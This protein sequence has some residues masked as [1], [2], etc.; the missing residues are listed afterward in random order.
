MLERAKQLMPMLQDIRRYAHQYP[1]EGFK[2]KETT[3]FIEKQLNAM[4]IMPI[5]LS[6]TGVTAIIRGC[7]DGPVVALRADIDALPIQETNDI[8]YK[9]K[10]EGIMHACG[11]DVH[12]A[13]L[14]G[15]A[16][17][18]KDQT[19]RFCGTVKLIFQPAE[20]IDAGAKYCIAEGVFEGVDAVFGLHNTPDLPTGYIGIHEGPAMAAT[21][22]FSLHI[23]GVGGH[24]A[25]P[26]TAKDPIVAASSIVLA[27]Q[28]IVSRN[29]SPLDTAVISCCAIQGG[30]MYNV[31]PAHVDI[32]GTVRTFSPAVQDMV[33]KR[34]EQISN[35]IAAGLGVSA[36][37]QYE[38]E[39]PPLIN[40]ADMAAVCRRAAQ[41]VLGEGRVAALM[42]YMISEDFA[43]YQQQI[44]G[45]FFFLGIGNAEKNCDK[46]LHSP[47]YMI[48]EEALPYGAAMLAQTAL[49]YLHR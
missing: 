36:S 16:K 22:K 21:D 39:L 28:T 27:L 47:D 10:H 30:Q 44:P 41:H 37:L 8:A 29:V 23:N 7:G 40:P 42:P 31:I 45:A 17:L 24:G 18:L 48:D 35:S 4:G 43:I 34:I 49:E 19:D 13:C 26:Q 1:E 25:Q 20:E 33:N 38:K 6:K 12:I 15:A 14:L 46:P 32:V 3:Q 9:S 5:R 11:H 2:E